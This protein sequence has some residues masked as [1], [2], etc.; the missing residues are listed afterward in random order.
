MIEIFGENQ[1]T[2][3]GTTIG[4]ANWFNSTL[5][6]DTAQFKSGA[7]SL[8]VVATAAGNGIMIQSVPIPANAV[9]A[10]FDFWCRFSRAQAYT[11]YFRQRAP[12]GNV[13]DNITSPTV[14]ADNAWH[15]YHGESLTPAKSYGVAGLDSGVETCTVFDFYMH[16]VNSLTGDE[17]WFDDI[18]C[19]IDTGVVK[20]WNGTTWV[21]RRMKTF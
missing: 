7:K 2:F 11:Q 18:S 5:S 14:P 13:V 6:L 20:V 8:K 4:W 19:L 10:K 16:L 15:Q 12:S 9:H 1:S 3:E 21:T 17:F